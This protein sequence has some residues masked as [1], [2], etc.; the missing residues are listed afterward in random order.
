LKRWATGKPGWWVADQRVG[1]PGLDLARYVPSYYSAGRRDLPV[2]GRNWD[3]KGFRFVLSPPAVGYWKRRYVWPKRESVAVTGSGRRVVTVDRSGPPE[4]SL[5][6][7]VESWGSAA[8]VFWWLSRLSAQWAPLVSR[9]ARARNE[10]IK[11]QLSAASEPP[12]SRRTM[13]RDGTVEKV[14]CWAW[15]M[16]AGSVSAQPRPPHEAFLRGC[17]R[18]P[19]KNPKPDSLRW[20][21]G[22]RGQDSLGVGSGESASWTRGCPQSGIR[23]WQIY[24]P[25][26][27]G[28]PSARAEWTGRGFLAPLRERGPPVGCSQRKPQ[29]DPG[30]AVT[31]TWP[32]VQA[33]LC[34]GGT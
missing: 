25:R 18:G 34:W 28:A 20:P 32:R 22:V 14:R 31:S 30:T 24:R 8:Q 5:Q 27:R 1:S 21:A 26:V 19:T 10:E 17:H 4:V 12:I 29:S 33:L 2:L 7:Y 23:K 3:M 13:P 9:R 6:R 16:P 15:T 11:P